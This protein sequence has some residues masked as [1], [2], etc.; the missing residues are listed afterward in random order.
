METLSNT[1]RIPN[2]F[3]LQLSQNCQDSGH[4]TVVQEPIGE[5]KIY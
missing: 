2:L 1:T 4:Q 5:Y 3:A